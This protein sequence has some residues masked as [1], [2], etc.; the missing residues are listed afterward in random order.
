MLSPL[1]RA[2]ALA[3]LLAAGCTNLYYRGERIELRPRAADDALEIALVYEQVGYG[4]ESREK[5]R[6]VAARILRGE[7]FFVFG[8]WPFVLDLENPG[9]VEHPFLA[10]F[11]EATRVVGSGAFRAETF[12]LGL[13]QCVRIQGWSALQDGIN[14]EIGAACAE[15]DPS[16]PQDPD[17]YPYDARTAELCRAKALDGSD[18]VEM[19]PDGLWVELPLSSAAAPRLLADVVDWGA[20]TASDGGRSDDDALV[21]AFFG[22]IQE[23]SLAGEVLKLRIGRAADGVLTLDYLDEGVHGDGELRAD[24]VQA[25][26][27]PRELPSLDELRADP[28]KL[29]RQR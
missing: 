26:L 16:A 14:R 12:E 19:R 10:R 15:F 27:I 25:G 2:A 5:S 13:W 20:E 4:A 21:R 22:S 17:A 24:L 23:L 3:S 8:A 18:W 1:R 28:A 11:A 6:E 29:G 9:V 7:R